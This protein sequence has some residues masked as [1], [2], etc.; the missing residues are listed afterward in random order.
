MPFSIKNR[1]TGDS[2]NADNR[3]NVVFLPT[4]PSLPHLSKVTWMVTGTVN[5]E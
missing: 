4:C 1:N 3:S 5:T 2:F